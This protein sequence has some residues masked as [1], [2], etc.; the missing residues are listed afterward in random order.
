MNLEGE[1][2]KKGSWLFRVIYGIILPTYVGIIV[3]HYKDPYGKLGS[4]CFFLAHLWSFFLFYQG[5]GSKSQMTKI[6]ALLVVPLCAQT[7][8]QEPFFL[9]DSASDSLGKI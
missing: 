3:D 7:L 4:F 1:H 8:G 2:W 9:S 5:L 6:F